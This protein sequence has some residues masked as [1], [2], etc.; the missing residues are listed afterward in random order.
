M[1]AKIQIGVDPNGVGIKGA[2]FGIPVDL[3]E[4]QLVLIP[5]PWNATASYGKG[6]I[7]G[8][9]AIIDASHQIDLCLPGIKTPWDF[10]MAINAISPH[11]ESLS[12]DL[13]G[14]LVPYLNQL[15]QGL[16]GSHYQ[17]IVD[18]V[19]QAG[20]N[21][22]L[23]V[24]KLA[25]DQLDQGKIVGVVGG[26][27]SVP[28]GLVEALAEHNP[29]FGVLQ[30]DAHADLRKAYQ[31]LIYSHASVMHNLL[32]IIPQIGQLV[33]VGVRDYCQEEWQRI[34]H[35]PRITAH[36]DASMKAKLF[37]GKNWS[38]I[39]DEIADDLPESVY[40]SFDIDGLD[41]CLCPGTGTPVPG[42]LSFDQVDFL[43]RNLVIRGKKIIGFDLC[44][45]AAGNDEWDGNVGARILYRLGT[46]TGVSQGQ[47][48]ADF[49]AQNL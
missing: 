36:H 46:Y 42:G 3:E 45:V 6:T 37:A 23:M 34:E 39:C 35:D 21:L 7:S 4:A 41:P 27:H 2:L 16:D 29:S 49:T 9:K 44:E 40:I 22:N 1:G 30:I 13:A 12:L 18:E 5:V 20:E 25:A 8:P 19:N 11:W 10:R 48:E 15:E 33:Q 31:G 24:N 38:Q 32:E 26:E 14:R 47:L 17:S 43:L 28:L